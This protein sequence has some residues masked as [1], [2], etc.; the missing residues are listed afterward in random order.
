[1]CENELWSQPLEQKSRITAIAHHLRTCTYICALP[2]PH[3]SV[4]IPLLYHVSQK[5]SVVLTSAYTVLSSLLVTIGVCVSIS[6]SSLLILFS[7]QIQS[8]LN[9]NFLYGPG[10]DAV[11][12]PYMQMAYMSL[13]TNTPL[14]LK[15]D[16]QDSGKVLCM[17]T[18]TPACQQAYSASVCVCVCVCV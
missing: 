4:A 1:M 2:V 16:P 15:I 9:Q 10:E 14:I 5:C 17:P 7:M 6:V 13:R 18:C 12:T 11:S 8:W 3:P